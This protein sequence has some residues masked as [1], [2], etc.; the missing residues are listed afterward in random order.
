MAGRKVP[1]APNYYDNNEAVAW[2]AGYEAAIASLAGTADPV[3]SPTPDVAVA[4]DSIIAEASAFSEGHT[5]SDTFFRIVGLAEAAKRRLRASPVSEA[6]STPPRSVDEALDIYAPGAWKCPK[7]DFHL[8]KHTIFMQSGTIGSSRDDVMNVT[9]EVC[10]NDGEP[11]IRE[12]WRERA[13]A[14]YKWGVDLM[15]QIIKIA[16]ADTL[17]HAL[18]LLKTWAF[19]APVV[20][21]RH[22]HEELRL[23]A[24]GD[25]IDCE[26][27][28]FCANPNEDE[29][30]VQRHEPIVRVA[31]VSEAGEATPPPEPRE[32]DVR[33]CPTCRGEKKHTQ[34]YDAREKVWFHTDN[35][36][37][38]LSAPVASPATQET[39]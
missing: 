29:D 11:M 17:P 30:D 32:G 38:P 16:G 7:C 12:T 23:D 9:G 22:C 14:N 20:K 10:P 28:T 21:C 4:L 36:D 33:Q 18:M 34:T 5:N 2:T 26:T 1:E 8:Q 37:P 31:P 3:A 24:D 35:Y 15:E 6:H 13:D 27:H 19:A 25:W 39:K